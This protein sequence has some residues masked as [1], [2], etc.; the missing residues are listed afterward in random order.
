MTLEPKEK[1]D[2][3]DLMSNYKKLHDEINKVEKTMEEF[4]KTLDILNTTKDA[5]IKGL[6]ENRE[7]ESTVIKR[8]VEKYGEGK[9][10]LT[11]FE[12]EINK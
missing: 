2:I 12:W 8:L 9:L 3:I 4:Q 5:V 11:N 10:N 7:T 6:E 1:Q